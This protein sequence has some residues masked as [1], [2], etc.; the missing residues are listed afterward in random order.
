MQYYFIYVSRYWSQ[1]DCDVI[2][3]VKYPLMTHDIEHVEKSIQV[4][5]YNTICS[6]HI[7]DNHDVN[8]VE[9]LMIRKFS[10]K[11]LNPKINQ[12]CGVW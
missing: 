2:L 6:G 3:P 7:N 11:L 8:M 4:V 5:T 9:V 10:Q 12:I 1:T